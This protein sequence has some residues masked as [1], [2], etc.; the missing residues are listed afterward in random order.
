MCALAVGAQRWWIL[1]AYINLQA[2]RARSR[3]WF[4]SPMQHLVASLKWQKWHRSKQMAQVFRHHR[5][6]RLFKKIAAE[7]KKE[8]NLLP[9]RMEDTLK[10][11]H[12]ES[13]LRHCR[14]FCT[15]Q[16]FKTAFKSSTSKTTQHNPDHRK[17]RT[18]F[19][20]NNC[21]YRSFS[22]GAI[23]VPRSQ[24]TSLLRRLFEI[25]KQLS[26]NL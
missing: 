19:S 23:W 13:T 7:S 3:R 25:C 1:L 6:C 15:W 26:N 18:F 16:L 22:H 2:L 5:G 20:A 11:S 12:Q 4:A 21:F 10:P 14:R 17:I 24:S 9:N 8:T